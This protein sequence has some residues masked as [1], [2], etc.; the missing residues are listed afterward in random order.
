MSKTLQRFDNIAWREKPL[1][2]ISTFHPGKCVIVVHKDNLVRQ[3][4]VRE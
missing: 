2:P 4:D 1:P 3:D